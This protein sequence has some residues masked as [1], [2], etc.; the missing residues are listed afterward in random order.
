[1]LIFAPEIKKSKRAAVTESNVSVKK[2]LLGESVTFLSSSVCSLLAEYLLF[3][4]SLIF[5]S[6][7]YSILF[8]RSGS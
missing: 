6:F 7:I 2:K 5:L 4:R 8:G 1:M 3:I